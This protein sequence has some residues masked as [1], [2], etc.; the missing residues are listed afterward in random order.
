MC[1]ESSTTEHSSGGSPRKTREKDRPIGN[2]KDNLFGGGMNFEY[3]G[4]DGL[5][6]REIMSYAEHT[7]MEDK[8]GTGCVQEYDVRIEMPSSG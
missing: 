4:G 2:E 7:S 8:G 1:N 6:K 5:D 3:V